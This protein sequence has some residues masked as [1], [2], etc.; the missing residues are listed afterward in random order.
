MKDSNSLIPRIPNSS[1]QGSSHTFDLRRFEPMVRFEHAGASTTIADPRWSPRLAWRTLTSRSYGVNDLARTAK[2]F[3]HCGLGPVSAILSEVDCPSRVGLSRW[4]I[5]STMIDECFEPFLRGTLLRDGLN[6]SWHYTQLLLRSFF[7]G[8]PGTHP[9]GIVALPRALAAQL[10]STEIR[11]DEEVQQVTS[12][13]VTTHKGT[14]TCAGVIVATDATGASHLTGTGETSWL[15]QTTWWMSVPQEYGGVGIRIDLGDRFFSSALDI[16]SVAPERSPSPRGLIAVPA[17]GNYESD[18][19]D[20]EASLYV[21]RLYD[22]A[23]TEVDLV[24][25]TVVARALP[26]FL[27][28]L[29]LTRNQRRGDL[30]LAGDYLQTPS[31]QGALVSGRRAAHVVLST[32]G[33]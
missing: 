14:Y 33:V 22:V 27:G 20:D 8:R 13:S 19:F 26:K 2:L 23:T 12:T 15:S 16:T 18:E 9:D 31:I 4:G 21:A 28:P 24:Q 29:N 5:S 6:D 32:L 11:L 3:A 30:V 10:L 1:R 25:K 7:R 17:N